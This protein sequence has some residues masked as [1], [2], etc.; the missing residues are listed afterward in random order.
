MAIPQQMS[1]EHPLFSCQ[2][3]LIIFILV[4]TAPYNAH[5]QHH[6]DIQWFTDAGSLLKMNFCWYLDA[7]QNQASWFIES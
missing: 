2:D 3:I 5:H 7:M 6:R 1:A 4:N